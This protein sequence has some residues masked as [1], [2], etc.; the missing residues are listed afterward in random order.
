MSDST[1]TG[2]AG[3]AMVEDGVRGAVLKGCRGLPPPFQELVHEVVQLSRQAQQRAQRLNRPMYGLRTSILLAALGVCAGIA[4]LLQ[5]MSFKVNGLSAQ[6]LLGVI[7]DTC[8]CLVLVPCILTVFFLEVRIKRRRVLADLK[9]LEAFNDRTYE[10]QFTQNAHSA[11]DIEDL[12][13]LL[14]VCCGLLLLVRVAA[15][16]YSG[17]SDSVVLER[18]GVIRRGCNDNHRNILMKISMAMAKRDGN[19]EHALAVA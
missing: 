3:S 19:P 12:I 16:A 2:P 17:S 14:D 9:V 6:D 10:M 11:E 4:W 18:I 5:S 13:Q 15:G 7:A 8:D 1:M